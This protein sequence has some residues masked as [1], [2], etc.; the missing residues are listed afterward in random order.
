VALCAPKFI[1]TNSQDARSEN[2][3]ALRPY[4]GPSLPCT[5]SWSRTVG[6]EGEPCA[7]RIAG[8]GWLVAGLFSTRKPHEM[9]SG[10]GQQQGQFMLD[11]YLS[12]N[13]HGN[14][15]LSATVTGLNP[16]L[17][18]LALLL[19]RRSAGAHSGRFLTTNQGELLV[20]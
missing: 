20:P 6:C 15:A 4:R 18:S 8:R 19:R 17:T 14:S 16:G 11:D 10:F 13:L 7:R 9:L 1:A 12:V 5:A 3:R 2:S